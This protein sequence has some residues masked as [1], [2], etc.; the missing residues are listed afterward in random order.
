MWAA[1]PPS[2]YYDRS[3]PPGPPGRTARLPITAGSSTAR[4]GRDPSGSHV[5]FVPVLTGGTRLYPGGHHGARRHAPWSAPSDWMPPGAGACLS[6]QPGPHRIPVPHPPGSRRFWLTRRRTPVPHVSLRESLAG[7]A[8]SGSTRTSRR[9]QG[10][11][12]PPRQRFLRRDGC[13][14]LRPAAAT[15]EP[16][17]P[18]TPVRKR[19]ASWRTSMAQ[20]PRA[21]EATSSGGASVMGREQNRV[22]HLGGRPPAAAA[23]VDGSG[24]SDP[25]HLGGAG[26]VDPCGGLDGLDGAPHSAPVGAVGDGQGRDVLPG[27]PLQLPLQARPAC[28]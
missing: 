25:D 27:R 6:R 15:T 18:L 4:R 19:S 21:Q 24:A 10:R 11:L 20:C 12:P 28:P 2:E 17:G 3:V 23:L 5:H 1:L 8:R 22:G 9:C 7:P 26:Q 14:Q 16:R 13:P